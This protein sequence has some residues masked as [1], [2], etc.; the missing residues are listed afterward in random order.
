MKLL[1]IDFCMEVGRTPERL[2]ALGEIV[3]TKRPEFICLQNVSNEVLKKIK[4]SMWGQR[5]SLT[6]PP[7]KFET[8]NKPQVAILSVYPAQRSDTL[9]YLSGKGKS[10]LKGHFLMF[11]K[12]KD[13]HI[14]T[15]CTTYL[16]RGK[17]ESKTREKQLNEALTSVI[18][19][20]DVIMAADLSVVESADGKPHL[21]GGWSDVWLEC[22]QGEGLTYVPGENP[23]IKNPSEQQERESGERPDRILS[24]LRRYRW[25][26][27]EVVGTKL[28]KPSGC[29]ISTHFGLLASFSML[30]TGSVFPPHPQQDVGC[31][32]ERH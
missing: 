13:P 28:H 8:R 5:Y 25:E 6:H 4:V 12:K 15:I 27:V 20:E 30:E 7:T 11:D 21:L 22:G 26:S 14:L 3:K 17:D 29:H 10:L 18:E 19:E 31:V 16:E 32:F 1:T 9:E 23:L 24:R 2:E